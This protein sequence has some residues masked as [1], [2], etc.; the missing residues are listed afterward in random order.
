VALTHILWCLDYHE[1]RWDTI[2]FFRVQ[3]STKAGEG[4]VIHIAV[5]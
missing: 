4:L 1:Q 2:A 3:P 5:E